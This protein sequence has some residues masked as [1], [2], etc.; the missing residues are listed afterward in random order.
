MCT[1]FAVYLLYP[2][3]RSITTMPMMGQESTIIKKNCVTYV[4][5]KYLLI[6]RLNKNTIVQ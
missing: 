4:K 6:R 1:L 2:V 5:Y 3:V